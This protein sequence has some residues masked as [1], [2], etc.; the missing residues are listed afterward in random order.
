MKNEFRKASFSGPLLSDKN[1][2]WEVVGVTSFGNGCGTR[3]FP[4]VYARVSAALGN[5]VLPT[6][7]YDA[8]SA[9]CRRA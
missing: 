3:N 1:G 8:G 4:G 5:F 9:T 6:S 7:D 2:R